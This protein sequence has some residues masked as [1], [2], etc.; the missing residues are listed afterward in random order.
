[1]PDNRTLNIQINMPLQT[2][3]GCVVLYKQALQEKLGNGQKMLFKKA[4]DIDSDHQ[5]TAIGEKLDELT[6]VLKLYSY[7]NSENFES[8]L[9]P[10]SHASIKA[11]QVVFPNA[12]V[13]ETSTCDPHSLV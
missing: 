11:A 3:D 2:Q 4:D 13:C 9:K 8:K 1:M 10:I 5:R 12:V 7:N 6:K